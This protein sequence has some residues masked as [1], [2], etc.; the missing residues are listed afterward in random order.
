MKTSFDLIN[1]Y[2]NV[3]KT[4][5]ERHGVQFDRIEDIHSLRLLE[6]SVDLSERILRKV[7]LPNSNFYIDLLP[8]AEVYLYGENEIHRL[9]AK[10]ESE[11]KQY[12]DEVAKPDVIHL[13]HSSIM[14]FKA[15]DVLIEMGLPNHVYLEFLYNQILRK[16]IDNSRNVLIELR[17]YVADSWVLRNIALAGWSAGEAR[18][19]MM[20]RLEKY[21]VAYL[22]EFLDYTD[23]MQFYNLQKAIMPIYVTGSKVLFIEKAEEEAYMHSHDTW[24]IC[25]DFEA[26]TIEGPESLRAFL[27]ASNWFALHPSQQ[28][29]M[30]MRLTGN[31]SLNEIFDS[32]VVKFFEM[33]A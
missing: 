12:F 19:K 25:V 5:F 18:E 20:Q 8:W 1:S 24:C 17:K 27:V 23:S 15:E 10:L 16:G 28:E 22:G 13:E 11:S 9:I 6:E 31:F 30:L 2:C 3:L 21:E 7:G 29:Q 4:L 33:A 14:G 32:L 26:K